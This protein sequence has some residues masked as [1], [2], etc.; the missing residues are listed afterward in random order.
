MGKIRKNM[1]IARF[2]GAV[3]FLKFFEKVFTDPFLNFIFYKSVR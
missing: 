3:P 1:K 2:L